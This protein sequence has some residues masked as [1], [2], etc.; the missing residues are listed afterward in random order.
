MSISVT[1]DYRTTCPY[2]NAVLYPA[3]F[4][5]DSAPWICVICH[6][7]WWATELSEEA[8]KQFRPALCDFGYGMKL[9]EL[10]EKVLAEREAARARGTSVRSDQVQLLPLHLLQRLP[11]DEG[12]FGDFVKIEITR[13]GG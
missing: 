7:A 2:C 10:Q 13:K 11:Q 5:P 1:P 12:E 4:T 9:V 6:H 3:V 8:R